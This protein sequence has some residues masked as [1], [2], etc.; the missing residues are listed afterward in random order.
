MQKDVKIMDELSNLLKEAK[1]LYKQRKR[2]KA[3]AKSILTLTV[4][5]I[6]MNTICQIY[7]EG[8]DLYLSLENN[9]LQTQ[10]LEDDFGL[11]GYNI[12]RNNK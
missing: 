7:F 4:P 11:L 2:R 3:I 8:N 12:E 1:P 5:V 6:L 10:L 9:T